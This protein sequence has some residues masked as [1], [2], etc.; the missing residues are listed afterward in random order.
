MTSIHGYH[1]SESWIR[2]TGLGYINLKM[3]YF[4]SDASSP[5][6]DSLSGRPQHY[7][8]YHQYEPIIRLLYHRLTKSLEILQWASRGVWGSEGRRCCW[9]CNKHQNLM[10]YFYDGK[11]AKFPHYITEN[12]WSLSQ[13]DFTQWRR[14][15]LNESFFLNMIIVL[16]S[17]RQHTSVLSCLFTATL[18]QDLGNYYFRK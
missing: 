9:S 2:W 3:H 10:I 14:Q 5:S 12:T 16:Q 6:V 7:L 15:S 17:K 8:S 4:G 11:H 13:Q 1:S 18:H